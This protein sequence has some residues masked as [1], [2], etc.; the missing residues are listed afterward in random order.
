[1]V[2][3]GL[4]WRIFHNRSEK[5]P[6]WFDVCAKIR[7]GEHNKV[8]KRHLL[9]ASEVPLHRFF[10]R[11]HVDCADDAGQL[12]ASCHNMIAVPGRW[13]PTR[14]DLI[15]DRRGIGEPGRLDDHTLE[16]RD[17]VAFQSVV[18]FEQR[19]SDV[20]GGGAAKATRRC[21]HQFAIVHVNEVVID[22]DIAELVDDHGAIRKCIAP[23]QLIEQ[24]G[25]PSA[26]KARQYRH[27]Y[28][29]IDFHGQPAARSS[30]G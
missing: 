25:F 23:Q 19:R 10:D 17:G 29:L 8:R 27:R 15:D 6:A 7:L 24:S 22:R 28:R 21:H 18:E 5:G 13:N 1:M 2:A 9:H 20:A 11:G 16:R 30:C 14:C 4:T 12:K 26:Q 3:A